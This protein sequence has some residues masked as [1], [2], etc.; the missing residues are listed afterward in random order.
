MSG[1]DQEIDVEQAEHYLS[2]LYEIDCVW[3]MRWQ[4]GTVNPLYL[5]SEEL[6][7]LAKQKGLGASEEDED[8]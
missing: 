2:G 8:E 1:K 6:I 3:V 7:E 5:T 4:V